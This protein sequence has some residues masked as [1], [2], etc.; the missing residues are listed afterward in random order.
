LNTAAPTPSTG[1]KEPPA[2]SNEGKRVKHSVANAYTTWRGPWLSQDPVVN[3]LLGAGAAILVAFLLALS[4]EA[5]RGLR[6]ALAFALAAL[7]ALY[8]ARYAAAY[9]LSVRVLPLLDVF[10]DPYGRSSAVLDF[11]Q[12]MALYV[13]SSYMMEHR[14]KRKNITPTPGDSREQMEPRP[15]PG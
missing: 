10:T 8:V 11:T 9:S 7:H 13:A 1:G 12:L 6:R 4:L 2:G 3:L 14:A 5:P 15:G